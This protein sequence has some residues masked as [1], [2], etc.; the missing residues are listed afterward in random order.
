MDA[1][2]LGQCRYCKKQAYSSRKD[3]RTAGR[4]SFPGDRLQSYRCPYIVGAWHFGHVA[5][6][7]R[8]GKYTKGEY[9][10][11]DGAGVRIHRRRQAERVRNAA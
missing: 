5:A 11:P 3:A 4:R 7:V 9:Y 1:Q 10:G 6:E 2:S 8:A